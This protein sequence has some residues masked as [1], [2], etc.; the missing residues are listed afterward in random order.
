MSN[1]FYIDILSA[2]GVKLGDGPL[3]TVLQ[4]QDTRRLDALGELVFVIPGEDERAQ[5][6]SAGVRFDVFDSVDGYVG[7]YYYRAKSLQVQADGISQLTVVADDQLTELTRKSVNFRRTY[8]NTAVE[9]VVADLLDVAGWDGTIDAGIGNTSVTYEGES[10]LRAVDVLR[11]R[12][13]QHFRLAGL[14]TL[15]FGAFGS[16]SGLV[17]A[18]LPGQVQADIEQNT[19]IAIVDNLNFLEEGGEIFNRIIPLGAGQG[20]SQLTIADATLG[21]YAVETGTNDDGSNYYYIEDSASVTLYGRREKVLIFP[22][23]RPITNSDANIVNAANAL[24]LTAEAYIARHTAPK[25][26]YGVTVRA[27]RQTLRVGDLV[28]LQ[29]RGVVDNYSYVDVD[30]MFYVMDVT[31]RRDL[32]GTRTAQ[33]VV[34]TLAERRTADQDIILEI[35]NDVRAL[36]V[37]V[38]ITLAYSPVG[39]YT[40]RIDA[41]HATE[42][43]VRIGN[44]VTFLNYAIMRFKTSPLKSSVT[45]VSTAASSVDS[46]GSSSASSSG[47][48]S[49]S[50]SGASS[51]TTTSSGGSSSPTSSSG[52]GETVASAAG[53][54][55]TPTSS[56][57]G[58]A[59][60]SS[61]AGGNHAHEIPVSGSGGLGG[62]SLWLT[63][64]GVI[65]WSAAGTPGQPQTNAAVDHTHDVTIG[66]HTHTVTIGNHTHNVSTNNHSH[67][68]T[69][70]AHTHDMPHTHNIAHTHNIDHTHDV[71]IPAHNHTLTY[72][73]FQDTTYPQTITVTINGV[74]ET[75]ALGGPWALTNAAVEVELDITTYLVNASGGLRQNHRVEFGCAALSQGEI[76]FE[77]DMLLSIQAIAVA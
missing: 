46:S 61:A 21:T 9:T 66:N 13:G 31:R 73:L 74:D 34:S 52:G 2:A 37:N 49:A 42:F 51:A 50:S 19:S 53:G 20:V 57:G 67:T 41:T 48:S 60:V 14:S 62:N 72:G 43:T 59:S 71:T 30:D 10:V 65:F 22:N 40:Q 11:D 27:L 28:R 76:E 23:I 77:C 36:K 1:L 4:L 12:W 63:S 38:P 58:S 26:V 18:N 35:V 54:S 47:A 32:A 17:I 44:E 24:K 55:S 8:T 69:I 7:R 45:T 3:T 29:Y 56:S 6:I 16:D 39:P 70:S 68:V 15:E 33:L 25:I 64:G 5:Y 75:A